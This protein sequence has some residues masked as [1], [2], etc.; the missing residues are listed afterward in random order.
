MEAKRKDDW[1]WSQYTMQDYMKQIIEVYRDK[2]FEYFISPDGIWFS[3]RGIE[4]RDN[5][6]PNC[7]Q[8]YATA[9]EVQPK[10][11]LEVGC[12]GCYL[13]K[14]LSVI[15]PDAEIFGIDISRNQIEMG[16]WF[17]RLPPALVN[18][19]SLMDITK[20]APNRTFDFVYTQAVIMH[21]SSDKVVDALKN[22]KK[23][24]NKYV[25]LVEARQHPN[26]I[27][28]LKAVFDGWTLSYPDRYPQDGVLLTKV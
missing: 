10:S 21:M 27:E 16:K 22:I 3:D 4:F 13:L 1:D 18:N 5:L 28:N 12:G 6:H 15:L 14:N 11:V 9:Y 8:I 25:L 23:V 26:W 24:A 17:S 20:T 2:L 7:K 19:L